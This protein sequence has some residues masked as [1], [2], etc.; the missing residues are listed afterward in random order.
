MQGDG[1]TGE[2]GCRGF[3]AVG[4]LGSPGRPAWALAAVPPPAQRLLGEL[5][6]LVL[7]PALLCPSYVCG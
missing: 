6:L 3:A 2:F 5:V 7:P 4:G 1:W